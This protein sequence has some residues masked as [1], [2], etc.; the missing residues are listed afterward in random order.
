MKIKA[1]SFAICIL[2]LSFTLGCN[3]GSQ[4]TE[5]Q[6]KDSIASTGNT[7]T[8]KSEAVDYSGVYSTAAD[9]PCKIT[10][11]V[12]KAGQDYNYKIAG[13]KLDCSGKLII[14]N[15]NG[16]IYFSFDGQIGDN[17][18]KT[19][20]GQFLDGAIM[21]QNYGN[22]SNQ[23]QYFKNCDEKFLQFTKK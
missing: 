10:I 23:Y 15:Q 14:E 20:S 12:S 4:T 13:A 19:V 16:E 7:S 9:S 22:A 2:A 3:S 6:N 11:T 18:P 21:I 17:A 5:N 8:A 1:L